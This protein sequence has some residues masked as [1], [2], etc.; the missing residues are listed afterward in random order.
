MK[1]SRI[2]LGAALALGGSAVLFTSA[3][4]AQR[5][6]RGNRQQA[7]PAQPQARQLNL[8]REE[9]A[10]LASLDAAT[11][12]TDRAAQDAALAAARPV[13]RGADARYAF[14]RYQ[15]QIAIQRNDN[16]LLSQSV[17]LAVESNAAPP[18]EMVVY[19]NSQA[20][21]AT[22]ARDHQKAER[23]LNRLAQLR[24][25]DPDLL[26]RLGQVRV[27]TGRVAEGLQL[28][29][30]AI[31]GRQAASQPVP[32]GWYRFALRTAFD[33]RDAAIRGQSAALARG[34]VGAYPT[35]TNW[36]DALLVFRETSSLDAATAI[37][38]SRLMRAAGAL[39]GERDYHDLA[40]ALNQGGYPGE[41]KAVI[42]EGIARGQIS[43]GSPAFRALLAAATPRIAEDRAELPAA[44]AA[45]NSAATGVA[46]LRT[47]DALLGYG[48]YADAIPLYRTALA[49]GGVD[50]NLVN[51]RLGQALALAGNR[52][53]AEAAFRA[54]SGP[55]AE[56][57]N[58]WLVFLAQ[59][60]R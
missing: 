36:R 2:A 52:A 25:N 5:A 34:L 11:R 4:E 32:E 27:N 28:L 37:D 49:K 23:A 15:M 35:A 39:A 43:A 47:A 55:R 1:V 53:E 40:H 10:V 31:S 24:P 56:L 12:G 14:A 18:E 44:I 41:A 9:R 29:Q 60:R 26:V 17:D 20:Q 30:R 46:A 42:D 48:R 51:T 33:S 45:A 58:Y 3:A 57:A 19:L 16:A 59:P 22:D 38:V 54:I 50:A 13:V 7:Q 21:F 8:S 6:P